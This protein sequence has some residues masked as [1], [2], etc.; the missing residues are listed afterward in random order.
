MAITS[1]QPRGSPSAGLYQTDTIEKETHQEME[2]AD[3]SATP[4]SDHDPEE[5]K[6]N[7]EVI[8]AYIVRTMPI[9]RGAREH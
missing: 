9:D 2:H 7:K 1:A 5:G 6:L 3:I 8:M 4:I